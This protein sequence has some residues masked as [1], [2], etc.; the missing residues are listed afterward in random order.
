MNAPVR[1]LILS[2]LHLEFASFKPPAPD[3]FDIVV[4]AGGICPGTAA[5]RWA[6]R[7]S[8]FA[9]K[10]VVLVPGNHEFY[11]S[12]RTRLLRELREA[13]AGTN[14]HMLDRDEV[15]LQPTSPG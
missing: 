13:A 1:L 4:L 2:D 14:V 7:P 11:G 15:I 6:L 5:V 8:T 9:G 10:S 3:L 12:D